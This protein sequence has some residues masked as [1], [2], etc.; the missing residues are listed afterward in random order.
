MCV[1]AQ[2]YQCVAKKTVRCKNHHTKFT[3]SPDVLWNGE[4]ILLPRLSGICHLQSHDAHVEP[5]HA[6]IPPSIPPLTFA[7]AFLIIVRTTITTKT[8]NAAH[9]CL[10]LHAHAIYIIYT[11]YNI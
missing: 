3:R 2:E 9:A 10:H 4:Q 1:L 8:K 6:A 7:S 5:C 11:V